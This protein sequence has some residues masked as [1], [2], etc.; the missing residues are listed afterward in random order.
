M[1]IGNILNR[2]FHV[3]PKV[4]FKFRIAN[5]V[6]TDDFG[7][8]SVDYGPWIDT[9][10]MVQPGIVASFGSRNISEKEYKDFGLDFARGSITIWLSTNTIG[11]I[12]GPSTI[13][14]KES[15]D[16]VLWNDRIWN[17][18]QVANWNEYNGW[19]RCYCEEALNQP[20][21]PPNP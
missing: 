6:A 7:Q 11:T 20:Y 2:A 13:H 4:K 14:G 3:I 5:G 16:Q 8:R 12:H 21:T 17:V 18:V 9:E 15:T 1:R 10:G 19:R